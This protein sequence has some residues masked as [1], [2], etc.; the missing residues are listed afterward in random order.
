MASHFDLGYIALITY[1]I[2]VT[3][4]CDID[5]VSIKILN[6]LEKKNGFPS[7]NSLFCFHFLVGLLVSYRLFSFTIHFIFVCRWLFMG[8]FSIVF[9]G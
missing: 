1:K 2:N 4:H 6:I 5:Y 3:L 8:K 9:L 7:Y